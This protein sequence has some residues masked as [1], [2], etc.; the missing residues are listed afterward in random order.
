MRAATSWL[1][2]DSYLDKTSSECLMSRTGT[3]QEPC[4]A[5]NWTRSL[6][7]GEPPVVN[8]P[9]VGTPG[10]GETGGDLRFRS[11]GPNS[12]D[13]SHGMG[14]IRLARS[15]TGHAGGR[16]RNFTDDYPTEFGE[17]RTRRDGFGRLTRR[18]N[19]LRTQ[20][21]RRDAVNSTTELLV[22]RVVAGFQPAPARQRHAN[23]GG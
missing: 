16:R 8:R 6:Q 22:T 4:S 5:S 12:T 17:S 2:G 14:R 11:T 15:T 13:P 7:L 9:R 19:V 18:A 21:R 20:R 23:L 1:T 3:C 10:G